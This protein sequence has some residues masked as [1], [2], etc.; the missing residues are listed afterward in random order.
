MNNIY[1]ILKTMHILGVILFLGN[2]IVTAWW[3]LMADR[4]GDPIVVAFAQR[5]VTLTDFVF[6]AGGG[7]LLL[8]GGLGNALWY[9]MDY[10]HIPWLSWSLGLF[11]ASGV[12]WAAI[13]I[14]VQI[15]QARLARAFAKGGSIPAEYRRLG[16]IWNGF[17][18]LATMLPLIAVY[19]M[20]F[21]PV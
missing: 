17:G 8:L 16:R 11:I 18:L 12:I 4:H 19:L 14:P 7:A 2:I 21:K 9:G 6:T 20:V 5:Q 3:K 15:K 13:L 10:L 1:L